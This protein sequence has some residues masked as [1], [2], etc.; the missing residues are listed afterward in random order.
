MGPPTYFS[1][2]IGKRTHFLLRLVIRTHFLGKRTYILT[3]FLIHFFTHIVHVFIFQAGYRRWGPEGL[4]ADFFPP[5][6]GKILYS[7]F[8]LL[9]RFAD[10]CN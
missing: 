5:V 6:L 10:S 9:N 1:G 2:K 7:Y 4:P 8:F 3:R